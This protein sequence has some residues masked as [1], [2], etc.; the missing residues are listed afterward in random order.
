MKKLSA[1][2][3]ALTALVLLAACSKDAEPGG[4]PATGGKTNFEVS[5]PG[6]LETYAVEDPQAAGAITPFY[7]DVAVY[8]LDAG[9]NATYYPWTNAEIKAKQKRFEQVTEPT[10]V[11]VIVNTG[12]VILPTGT[13]PVSVIT[14]AMMKSSVADQNQL[15]KTLAVADTKG[16]AAGTY[17]SA[18]QVMLVGDQSVFTTETTD[19]GHTLKKAAVELSSIVSRF[20]IG[21]VK[22]GTGL[23]ALT[24]EAVYVNNFLNFNGGIYNSTVQNFTEIT[25]PATFTPAWATDGYNAAVTS[26][27]GTKAYAYQ[28]F[29]GNVVPHIIYKV[30]GTVSAGYKLSDGTGDE[31]TATP[32]TGKYITVKGF[33]ESGTLITVTQ[34]HK[35]Y[36]MGLED[37]GIEI[38]P[39]KITDRPEKTKIDL[40]VAITI[41]DWTT[42]NITPEI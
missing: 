28:V 40:T 30:G 21:T 11:F 14:A 39:D 31:N 19:D 10:Q 42:V 41:A 33:R 16:N 13:I 24:V 36:K 5:L 1:S 18:Q 8:L 38:T 29:S 9:G 20:E 17:S 22:K 34:P 2:L 15:A 23:D 27:A 3:C 25:W 26:A 6:A 37:G 12:S 7:N 32:F 35:I 4:T